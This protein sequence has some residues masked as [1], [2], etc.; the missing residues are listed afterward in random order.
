MTA[1]P[2]PVR[3]I[4]FADGLETMQISRTTAYKLLR[5]P[6]S[7]FLRPFRIS[8]RLCYLEGDVAA[9]LQRQAGAA[10]MAPSALPERSPDVLSSQ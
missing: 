10:Q 9:W 7:D 8:S 5:D 2:S 1:A 4:S 3:V 6:T